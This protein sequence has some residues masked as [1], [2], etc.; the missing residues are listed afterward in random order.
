MVEKESLIYLFLGEDQSAKDIKLKYIKELYVPVGTEYFNLDMLYGK[1][2][3]LLSL[4]EKI[5]ALPLKSK[6]RL[7]VIKEAEALSEDVK[8]YLLNY[9]LKPFQSV[10]IVLDISG[11]KIKDGFVNN[12]LRYAQACRFQAAQ[13]LDTF[14]L[15]N[16]IAMKKTDAALR[17]LNQLLKNGEKPER[18][19]GG[20]RYSWERNTSYS[21]ETGP[22]LKALLNCEL[23]IKTGRLKAD[24]ALERLVIALC[25]LPNAFC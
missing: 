17:V 12:M 24:F 6:K 4:Q 16:H 1:D 8:E 15:S 10:V 25:G 11:N 23:D 14:V 22:K 7:I 13:R 2:L 18:I 5:L 9:A 20:L 3:D 19:M 21:K